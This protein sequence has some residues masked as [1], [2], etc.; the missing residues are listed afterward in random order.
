MYSGVY[1]SCHSQASCAD[2]YIS[3]YIG[4][5]WFSQM[6]LLLEEPTSIIA[7]VQCMQAHTLISHCMC[8]CYSLQITDP[9]ANDEP[10]KTVFIYTL[11]VEVFDDTTNGDYNVSFTNRVDT[12]SVGSVRVTEKGVQY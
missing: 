11:T 10:G 1:R 7:H 6:A 2:F 9:C 3:S 12:A 4:S 5:L 8:V